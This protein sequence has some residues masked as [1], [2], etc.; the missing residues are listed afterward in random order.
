MDGWLMDPKGFWYARFHRDPKEWALNA[1]VVVDNGRPMP[2]DKAALLKTRR[3][4]RYEDAVAL[5]FQ[6]KEYG[7][8][9]TEPAW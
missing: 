8:T 2:G 6:L 4:M 7:W 3:S 9:V 5:W 1:G